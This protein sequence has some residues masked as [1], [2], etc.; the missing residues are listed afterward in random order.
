MSTTPEKIKKLPMYNGLR[1][2][3]KGPDEQSAGAPTFV[4]RVIPPA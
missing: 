4:V 2:W 1:I 3:A